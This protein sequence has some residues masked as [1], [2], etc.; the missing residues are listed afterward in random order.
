MQPCSP[1]LESLVYLRKL[2]KDLDMLNPDKFNIIETYYSKTDL[3][4]QLVF[5]M[6]EVYQYLRKHSD[7]SLNENYNNLKN[8]F[9]AYIAA[10]IMTIT[11]NP[12]FKPTELH[13]RDV[14][15]ASEKILKY[16]MNKLEAVRKHQAH[17]AHTLLE[18][19]SSSETLEKHVLALQKELQELETKISRG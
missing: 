14:I 12:N 16:E 5:R 13:I 3:K 19:L 9:K 8:D 18:A 10:R 7:P 4:T 11:E 17:E 15:F 2:H 1:S 6:A